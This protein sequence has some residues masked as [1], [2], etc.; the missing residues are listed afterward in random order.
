MLEN[1]SIFPVFSFDRNVIKWEDY[2]HV[3]TPVQTI[4]DPFLGKMQFKRED[5]FAPLG[6]G[7]V[8]G[9]KGRAGLW[10]AYEHFKEHGVVDIIHGTVVH[11]PQNYFYPILAKHFGG[12]CTTVLGAT[13]PATCLN[14]PMVRAAAILGSDFNF[15]SMG[16]NSSLQKRCKEF[17]AAHP[18]Y[19]YGE[20]GITLDHNVHPIERVAEFAKIGGEQV[21]N[22]PDDVETLIIPFGSANSATG[23]F[24]G[25]AMYPKPNLKK[26]VLIGIGPNRLDWVEERL[27]AIGKHLGLPT[28]TAWLKNYHHGGAAISGKKETTKKLFGSKKPVDQAATP[29]FEVEHYDL[30]TTNW[31][32]YQDLMQEDFGGLE[33]HPRYEGKVLR[34][35]KENAPELI[36]EKSLFWV[37]GSYPRIEPMLEKMTQL[38][39]VESVVVNDFTPQGS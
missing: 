30:H 31:V 15:V 37:V 9:T 28:I 19:L 4:E 38:H 7:A 26:V 8:N 22:I 20:Y 36:N 10:L 29:V 35:I 14:H 34:Y 6:Y 3:L 12:K 17:K 5:Y 13:K 32:R 2:L 1:G 39:D 33:M 27:N 25:L 24:T 21:Q 16:Y 23:I 11:S 18:E